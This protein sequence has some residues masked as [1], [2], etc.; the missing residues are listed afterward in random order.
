MCHARCSL[1]SSSSSQSSAAL[2]LAPSS[3]AVAVRINGEVA[4]ALPDADC[5]TVWLEMSKEE[6]HMYNT[7]RCIQPSIHYSCYGNYLERCVAQLNA[8]SHLYDEK[9]VCGA[10]HSF[11]SAH[12]DS[13]G[14]A[15]GNVY[16]AQLR[17]YDQLQR[18]L[19][20]GYIVES[21][22]AKAKVGGGKYTTYKYLAANVPSHPHTKPYAEREIYNVGEGDETNSAYP[23]KAPTLEEP[24]PHASCARGDRLK[25]RRGSPAPAICSAAVKRC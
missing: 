8:C 25:L 2:C 13:L 24:S 4:L 14:L 19:K 21:G 22:E 9:V 12:A 16:A 6:R 15:K 20:G 5:S 23:R 1:L 7:H 11:E 3:A 10:H 18:K 17:S